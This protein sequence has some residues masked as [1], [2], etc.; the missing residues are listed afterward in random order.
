MPCRC[1]VINYSQW[2]VMPVLKKKPLKLSA[3]R[4]YSKSVTNCAA[5]ACRGG[6]NKRRCTEKLFTWNR[7]WLDYRK[8][9]RTSRCQKRA[10][11]DFL[12]HYVH[13]RL[14]PLTS[15]EVWAADSAL[16]T[17]PAI[18]SLPEGRRTRH[19]YRSPFRYVFSPPSFIYS[20]KCVINRVVFSFFWQ[21]NLWSL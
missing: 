19:S 15:G 16:R 18:A 3:C 21:F 7:R 12:L 1:C 10:E 17:S 14:L 13:R 2:H 8:V 20:P 9:N 6:N 11:S 5:G 4:A